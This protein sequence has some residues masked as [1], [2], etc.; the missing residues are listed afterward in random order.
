[1]ARSTRGPARRPARRHR[2]GRVLLALVVPVV[3]LGLAVAGVVAWLDQAVPEPEA[4]DMCAATVDGTTWVL[5][6][7]QARNAG[8]IAAIGVRRELPARAVTIA[9]A[10]ALQ[11]SKL[12]NVDYGDRDSVGLFQQRPSQG[13]GTVEEIMDPAYSTR[14]FYEALVKVDGYQDMEITDAAQAVQRS[15]F[16]DAYGNHEGRARAWASALT[17]WSPAAVT[18]EL[19]DGAGSTAAVVEAVAADL[20]AD[21]ALGDDGVTVTV[22]VPARGAGER[23][24]W[25]AAQW[26]VAGAGAL[27]LDRVAVADQVWDRDDAAWS[28]AT[29]PLPAGQVRLTVAVPA[30]APEG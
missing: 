29:A 9:L 30:D 20:D 2:R 12:V 16:P 15:A 13:W 17:G 19:G 22:D 4:A 7:E 23:S 26:A 5:D 10:T 24:A 3:L 28:A 18:C 8:L 14:K 11:E 25:A 6:P 27:G 21:A 1:M